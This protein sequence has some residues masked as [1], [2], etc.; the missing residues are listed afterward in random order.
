MCS[1]GLFVL[2]VRNARRLGE[3]L[4]KSFMSTALPKRKCLSLFTH[5]YADEMSDEVFICI[6]VLF[7]F[8]LDHQT[9]FS[10]TTE[11]AGELQEKKQKEK[12]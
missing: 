2:T 1:H 3:T 10:E 6:I 11:E 4:V 7:S 8:R 5:P 9:R 12:S